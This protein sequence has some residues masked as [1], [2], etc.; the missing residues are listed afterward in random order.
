LTPIVLGAV[1]LGDRMTA[2]ELA[3]AAIIA[4]ALLVI[5]GRLFQRV[6]RRLTARSMS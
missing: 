2:R 5:D 1:F 3:G 6:G 4:S